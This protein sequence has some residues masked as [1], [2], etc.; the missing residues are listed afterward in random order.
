MVRESIGSTGRPGLAGLV[1]ASALL[2]VG[3]SSGGDGDTAA[4]PT[5]QPPVTAPV[6]PP[7]VT[8][9]APEP[10]VTAPV[11]QS[12]EKGGYVDNGF[13]DAALALLSRLAIQAPGQGAHGAIRANLGSGH[14]DPTGVDW[15][16]ISAYH[17]NLALL[18]TLRV[19]PAQAPM[20][21]DWLRWQARHVSSVGAQQGMV[22]D[23]WVR[24]TDLRESQCPPGMDASAC[25]QVDAYDSTA[26]S[27]LLMADG[28]LAATGDAALLRET[29]V[30]AAL[31]AMAATMRTLTPSDGLSLAKPDYPEQY[32]MDSVEVAAGWRAWARVQQ[33]VYADATGASASLAAAQRTENAMR[34]RL[35]HA[36]SQA[37]RVSLQTGAPDFTVWYADTV[38]QAWP[39]LWGVAGP[40]SSDGASAWRNAIARW[41][42]ENDWSRRNVDPDGFWWPAVAAAA[43][44]VGDAAGAR[45]W[46][47]RARADWLKPSEPFA[48]PFQVGDLRWLFWLSDP[49]TAPRP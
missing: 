46:V 49:V 6:T 3:C 12:C 42:G 33:S 21:A 19:A 39:L 36:P 26:A 35:W 23:H 34:Q 5:P 25:P 1:L 14:T 37:W 18:E 17:V 38:A 48:W 9:P 2:L 32:L 29:V 11:A 20:V 10:P 7:P 24:S 15:H 43:V 44:C 28:Y 40:T 27:V 45:T 13:R 30:R 31:V 8:E 41:Q 47:A 16:Y 22:F 4:T